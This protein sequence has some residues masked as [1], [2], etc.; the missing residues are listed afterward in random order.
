MTR[1][2][3]CNC[4]SPTEAVLVDQFGA[5]N[6]P[7]C[8]NSVGS[9]GTATTGRPW[10]C[11][12]VMIS[13]ENCEHPWWKHANPTEDGLSRQPMLLPDGM[14]RGPYNGEPAAMYVAT[15]L[16][17]DCVHGDCLYIA[18][19]GT[20]P[21]APFIDGGAGVNC[22]SPYYRAGQIESASGSTT[23]RD[24]YKFDSDGNMVQPWPMSFDLRS[25]P[26]TSTGITLR[27]LF[28]GNDD[29]NPTCCWCLSP[30]NDPENGPCGPEVI[31]WDGWTLRPT[32]AYTP[33]DGSGATRGSPRITYQEGN[34]AFWGEVGKLDPWYAVD[35]TYGDGTLQFGNAEV[36]QFALQNETY[37]PSLPKRVCVVPIIW[38]YQNSPC[39]S[40]TEQC[41]SCAPSA[42]DLPAGNY[43]ECEH[44]MVIGGSLEC[45][46]GAA[47]VSGTILSAGCGNGL[48][49]DAELNGTL[50][51]GVSNPGGSCGYYWKTIGSIDNCTLGALVYW[52]GST[53]KVKLYTQ[54]DADPFV[55]AGEA[56]TTTQIC[57][58][59][60]IEFD[61][62]AEGIEFE[63][64]GS[65]CVCGDMPATATGSIT[66]TA[67]GTGSATF[68]L[69]GCVYTGTIVTDGAITYNIRIEMDICRV[70]IGCEGDGG[71]YPTCALL[72]TEPPGFGAWVVRNS[73]NPL[74]IEAHF[75]TEF[76][77]ECPEGL[78]DEVTFTLVE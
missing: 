48:I 3:G 36:T 60:G 49:P 42:N 32:G 35:S 51:S 57:G 69:S 59:A 19:E 67:G 27:T 78:L 22:A 50:P 74:D 29:D 33:A 64:C 53:W 61:F 4:H 58:C 25:I 14:Y 52:N 76:L 65:C 75:R 18:K 62:S 8:D 6:H 70:C 20:G 31:S 2:T 28:G 30:A 72:G 37:W 13:G 73:C 38:P 24:P 40:L 71:T 54:V 43:T 12:F 7:C 17:K 11:G 9:A 15:F 10:P 34:D 1:C 56:G 47:N 44:G 55:D 41:E 77:G 26:A 66:S 46:D 21:I 63:C 5:A 23:G 39:S 16:G 45:A 68:T